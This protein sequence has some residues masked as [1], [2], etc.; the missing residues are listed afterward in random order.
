MH[1]AVLD[2]H[3]WFLVFASVL[4]S[5]FLAHNSETTRCLMMMAAPPMTVTI[6]AQLVDAHAG[7][8]RV[9]HIV[10]RE[11]PAH[12]RT[13]IG[14]P[15]YMIPACMYLVGIVWAFAGSDPHRTNSGLAPGWP[16]LAPVCAG[17]PTT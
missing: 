17:V 5:H 13:T 4:C 2:R 16:G 10:F 1:S 8:I 7:D 12:V 11:T 15:P 9:S 6:A 14:G 3:V